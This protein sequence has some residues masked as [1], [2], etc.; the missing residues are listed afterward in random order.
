MFP[1]RILFSLFI[2]GAM[3]GLAPQSLALDVKKVQPR[4]QSAQSAETNTMTT[5]TVETTRP[6]Y[7][8]PN[9]GLNQV[10]PNSDFILEVPVEFNGTGT[11]SSEYGAL[12]GKSYNQI[13]VYCQMHFH[14]KDWETPD[15]VKIT[16][17]KVIT[18]GPDSSYNGPVRFGI[19]YSGPVKEQLDGPGRLITVGVTGPS[20]C[21]LKLV[22]PDGRHVAVEETGAS[23]NTSI[24]LTMPLYNHF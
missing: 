11:F 15:T 1:N 19:E 23:Y 14:D 20:H 21:N 4:A 17:T 12:E 24:D 13:A 10:S 2:A 3:I 18:L 7:S 8:Q 6:V 16:E 22:A 5:K 9:T